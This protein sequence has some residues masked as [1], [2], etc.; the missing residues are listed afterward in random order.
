MQ[1]LEGFHQKDA[2]LGPLKYVFFGA[3]WPLE[4]L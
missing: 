4:E 3:K 1:I 2:F